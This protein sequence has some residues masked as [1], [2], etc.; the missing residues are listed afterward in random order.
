MASEVSICNLALTKIGEEQILSLTEDSKAGR[1]CNLH[2]QP[3][4]DTVLRSHLWNF[5]M[6]RATLAASTIAPEYDFTTQFPLPDDFIRIV[7]TDLLRGVEWKI[8][9]G[10]LLTDDDAVK[11]RYVSKITDPNKFDPMFIE[12]LAA[13]IAAELSQ[14][15]S[16]ST[17]LT[18]QMFQLYNQKMSEARGAD[19]Q[20]GTPDNIE[21]DAWLDARLAY[22]SP[23]NA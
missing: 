3:I 2:Y 14:P 12:A 17:T 15:L 19:A 4:R 18:Q 23:F 9:S 6:K 20:E 21:A 1:L 10:H 5:A 7:D 22:V 8:E 11:I 13:R 16:D